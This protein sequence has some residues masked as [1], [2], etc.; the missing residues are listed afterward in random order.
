MYVHDVCVCVRACVHVCHALSQVCALFNAHLSP[1][2]CALLRC[3]E[4]KYCLHRGHCT[5]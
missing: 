3:M 4:V 2:A 1:L 5:M